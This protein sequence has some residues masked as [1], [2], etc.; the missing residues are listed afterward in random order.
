MAMSRKERNIV[1][2]ASKGSRTG[3]F[4]RDAVKKL[5]SVDMRDIT[6]VEVDFSGISFISRAV[7]HEFL[8]WSRKLRESK[9]IRVEFKGCTEE[10]QRMLDTVR[11]S[12]GTGQEKKKASDDPDPI[13]FSGPKAFEDFLK[14]G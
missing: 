6:S 14:S 3:I 1:I 12:M 8:S 9:Y 2:K 13:R 5:F 7:A 10:V 11:S 4:S